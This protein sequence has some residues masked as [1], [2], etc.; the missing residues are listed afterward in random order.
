MT[1]GMAFAFTPVVAHQRPSPARTAPLV[2]A[3]S[4]A[5]TAPRSDVLQLKHGCSAARPAWRSRRR[6]ALHRVHVQERQRARAR[7]QRR[8]A[9]QRDQQGAGDLLDLPDVPQD[10][11]RRNEPSVEG[12]RIPSNNLSIPP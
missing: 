7:Q 8:V 6:E 12:A 11:P 9:G 1:S 10:R 3:G 4:N 2:P 5:E